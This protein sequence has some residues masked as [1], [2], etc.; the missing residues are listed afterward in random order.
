MANDLKFKGIVFF[1]E[2][3]TGKTTVAMALQEKIPDS[4]FFEISE[5]IIKR[6][7]SVR[8]FPDSI[9]ELV[10]NLMSLPKTE[11]NREDAR[12]LFVRLEKKYKGDAIAQILGELT[13][14][15]YFSKSFPII[16]GARGL[17]KA[18]YL[19]SLGYLI[20]FLKTDREIIIERRLKQRGETREETI[21]DL[22]EEEKIYQT[23]EIETM[24]DLIFDTGV[25][26]I[27]YI[28]ILIIQ[29]VESRYKHKSCR[30]QSQF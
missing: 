9:K 23:S 1:G 19:K 2:P 22:E 29:T 21:K 17:S 15:G 3:G 25:D 14:T 8:E 7:A 27:P 24:A 20:V 26:K 11:I 16:P 6:L 30:G 10:K 28:H 4:K 18:K 13:L 12:S 5:E